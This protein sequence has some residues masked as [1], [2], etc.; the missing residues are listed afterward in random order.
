MS[1]VVLPFL[2]FAIAASGTPGPNNLLALAT[3]ARYGVRAALPL[4]LGIALGF[5]FMVAVVGMGL[6]GPLAHHP[7]VHA[8][9]RW[10]GTAWMLVLAWRIARSE[11]AA[12]SGTNVAAPLGFWGACAFQWINPKAWIMAL[13]TAATYTTPGD[14]LPAQVLLL[15]AIFVVISIPCVGAW[16]LLG[17][18]ASTLL[19]TP[20]RMRAFN[21]VMGSLLAASV[22]PVLFGWQ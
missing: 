22:L 13:A 7:A 2:A 21:L 1:T 15:S 11:T 20:R 9:M 6:A 17:A 19:T 18:G 3:A 4:V 10:I 14:D 12:P 16:A 5:G 8:G